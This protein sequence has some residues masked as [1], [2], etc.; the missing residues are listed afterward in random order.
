MSGSST[1]ERAAVVMYAALCSTAMGW[2]DFRKLLPSI[3]DTTLVEAITILS[4][5]GLVTR[6][7][8]YPRK[9]HALPGLLPPRLDGAKRDLD[10]GMRVTP[11]IGPVERRQIMDEK[12]VSDADT[13]A[14][15]HG[16]SAERVRRIWS[17]VA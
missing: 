3:S 10:S 12:G 15:A 13:V 7:E 16:I 8:T 1:A 9:Y 5:T 6:M 17:G 11:H 4:M 2:P 14:K